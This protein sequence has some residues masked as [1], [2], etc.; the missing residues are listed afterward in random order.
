MDTERKAEPLGVTC[1]E[2]GAEIVLALGGGAARGVAHIGVIRTLEEAGFRIRGVA[3]TSIGAVVGGMYC[4][5]ELEPFSDFLGTVDR[6]SVFRFLDPILPRAG[7]FAGMRLEQM[8]S[9]FVGA[10]LVGDLDVPFV[11]VAVDVAG[12]DEVRLRDCALVDA[13]RASFGIPG[14]F[15][16]KRLVVNGIERWLVDG[17]VASPVPVGAAKELMDLPVVAVN[18]NKGFER[19]QVLRKRNN[20]PKSESRMVSFLVDERVPKAAR[21][22]LGGVFESRSARDTDEASNSW[23][24]SRW[25]GLFRTRDGSRSP[26]MIDSLYNSVV[27]LQHHLARS[28]FQAMPPA[29]LIEPNLE[30]VGLFDFHLGDALVDEGARATRE[31]LGR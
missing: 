12:G 31:V 24:V 25:L 1:L 3:G 16:P 17:G 14:L 19:P 26:G 29:M 22:F 5:G 9:G 20:K 10:K 6:R 27:L 11:A 21:D 2:P 30:G 8:I 7:L 15:A 28:Q 13:I 18:V 4:A 23:S